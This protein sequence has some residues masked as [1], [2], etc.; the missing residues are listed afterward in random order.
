MSGA[1]YVYKRTGTTWAQEAY[2]K[3]SNSEAT[4]YFGE[5]V[6]LDGDTLAVGAYLEDSSQDT[7]TNGTTASS[8][9]SSNDSGA[10]YVYK[11]TGTTW[12]QEAY[13]K[14]SNSE[15]NDYFGNSVA[16]DGDTLVVGA[17]GEDSNQTTITNDNST[18]SSNNSNSRSGAVYVYKRTG[19]TW[20]QEA[21]VKASN[22]EAT[23]WFGSS[24][25][26]DGDTLAV[27]AY[28]EESSQTTITNDNST[29]SSDNSNN[30]S[31]AVY[32]YKRTGT[33]WAQEAYVKASNSEATDE[34]GYSV[35]L[36]NDTLAVGVRDEDSNQTTITNDNS[37]A[38]SNNSSSASG[39]V[40]V[41]KRTGTTWEQE[42]YVKASN[43]DASDVFGYRVALDGDTLA[44]GAFGEDSNQT[45]ITN[46]N[47]TASS[48]NSSDD[49]G[50]VYVYK[51][52][53]TT[54]AQEAYVK[55]SNNDASDLFGYYV[56]LDGDTLAVGADY[57]D[58]N[59]TT[60]T[61]GTSASSNNS[62]SN[63]GAVYVY[64]WAPSGPLLMG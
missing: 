53:G 3:A 44:V 22:S 25:A 17:Y 32:V 52:T 37:T 46:D 34:F 15:A 45:T 54:W 4:D 2:I 9:N 61:N 58:S 39:A 21:Y 63:S 24:V 27:G 33:T 7:I 60:I 23:D 18:A 6:A 41:Y 35:A 11:R 51:R 59:Q 31:G 38:S 16:L 8:N 26:L 49:S 40:Y 10:V 28:K 50:A 36:D 19:T 55:A 47:S 64:N 12:E 5:V 56:A 14:A 48:N 13:I 20:T 62:S 30:R 29:A 42:A 57:E 43:N 1:V